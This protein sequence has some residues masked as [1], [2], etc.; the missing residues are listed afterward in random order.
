VLSHVMSR[1]KRILMTLDA[2]GGL[3]RYSV[4]LA[5]CLAAGG[6]EC[7]L[8]GCGPAPS[9]AQQRECRDLRDVALTWT[10]LPLDWMVEDESALDEVGTTLLAIGREWDVDLLH[11]NLPSQA[12]LIPDG[13][14]VV[15]T[16]HSCIATWWNAV[17]GDAL[18]P[19]WQW[20]RTLTRRGLKRADAVMV[21]TISHGQ[22][23]VAAYGPLPRL[24]QV[25]NATAMVCTGNAEEP[26]VFAA[27]R[28]WDGGKNAH[29]LDAAAA[30]TRWPVIMA[31]ALSGPN[32]QSVNLHHA[33][34]LGELAA[35]DTRALMSRAAIFASP[36]IYE[37]FGLAVLEAAARGA[38]LV[39]SD[40]PTFRELWDAAALFVQPDD[41]ERFA[42]AIN[43][44]AEDTT[45]R[46]RLGAL[47]RQRAGAFTSDRQVASVQHVY[48]E[49][50]A[51]HA[52]ALATTG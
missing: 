38:A 17:R 46:R 1:P 24:H 8:V 40:I 29:T 51:T 33:T 15:V 35:D 21:P 37:P 44:L 11:L 39:L 34:S 31:G 19:A 42:V 52:S 27:G 10:Q 4:D 16:S 14:P 50:L 25:P 47:A 23:L 18:P 3:W 30:W 6:I 26:T 7:V 13:T 32:G 20:Q 28:W 5:R 41:A 22:A 49:A 2:V 45:L 48:A 9:D 12:A 36:A 43:Q